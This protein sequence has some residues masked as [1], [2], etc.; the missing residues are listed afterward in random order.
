M[1]AKPG[2]DLMVGMM[3]SDFDIT[4]QLPP[5]TM[6][7]SWAMFIRIRKEDSNG[8]DSHCKVGGK[9]DYCVREKYLITS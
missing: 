8:E 2:I 7:A 4:N 3:S 1:G 9:I 5:N 6:V